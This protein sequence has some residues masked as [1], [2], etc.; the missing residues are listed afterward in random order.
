ME[1]KRPSPLH[2]RSFNPLSWSR[3]LSLPSYS[4]KEK[5]GLMSEVCPGSYHAHPNVLKH[6]RHSLAYA[7]TRQKDAKADKQ[8]SCRNCAKNKWLAFP[9]EGFP[10]PHILQCCVMVAIVPVLLILAHGLSAL[11]LKQ[12]ML[13]RVIS[14]P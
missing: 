13:K 2:V 9:L 1:S 5:P 6:K 3:I 4:R 10:G 12:N 14:I 7:N 11:Q 8:V